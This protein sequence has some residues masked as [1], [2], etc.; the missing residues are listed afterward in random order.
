MFPGASRLRQEFGEGV[1]LSPFGHYLVLYVAHV[2]LLE[3]RRVI[4][5]ARNLPEIL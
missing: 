2:D 1:R 5:G 3:I 4:H